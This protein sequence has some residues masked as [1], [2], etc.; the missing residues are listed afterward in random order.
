MKT[1]NEAPINPN[2]GKP[3][4]ELDPR[5][6]GTGWK[7]GNSVTISCVPEITIRVFGRQLPRWCYRYD[8]A[9][10]TVNITW[11]GSLVARALAIMSGYFGRSYPVE[12]SYPAWFSRTIA[13]AP[14]DNEVEIRWVL[15][16]DG[17]TA[18]ATRVR[19]SDQ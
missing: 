14:P 8:A 7:V 12:F 15:D 3:Y 5:G 13:S 11:F 1:M 4:F 2:T 18:V 17:K 6:F 16:P 19:E 10:G 9:A